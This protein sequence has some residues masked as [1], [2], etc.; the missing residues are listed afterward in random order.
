MSIW[1][2]ISLGVGIFWA[3]TAVIGRGRATV[4]TLHIDH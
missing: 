4:T 1:F 3:L 2:A